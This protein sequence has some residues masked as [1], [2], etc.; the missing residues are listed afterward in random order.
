MPGVERVILT[1]IAGLT[2]LSISSVSRTLRNSREISEAKKIL[3]RDAA[4][5]LSCRKHLQRPAPNFLTVS[6][7]SD[8]KNK[9]EPGSICSGIMQG[10]LD[11]A[12]RHDVRVIR[13][14]E[15]ELNKQICSPVG[16]FESLI[17]LG[18]DDEEQFE[19]LAATERPIV[20]VNS[21]DPF[22]RID[23]VLPDNAGCGD[24]VA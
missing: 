1:D 24:R 6:A 23:S 5:R 7:S 2:G 11:E 22:G 21:Q 3:V 15:S 17:L 14:T 10:I 20:L 8:G 9:L 19:A 12:A 16:R 13:L 4:A 18:C